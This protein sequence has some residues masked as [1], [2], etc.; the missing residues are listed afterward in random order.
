MLQTTA[1]QVVVKLLVSPGP[2]ETP[3]YPQFESL[4]GKAQSDWTK[5]QTGRAASA[6]EIAEVVD[7]LL[8]ADCGWLNGVDIPVDGGFTAGME[9]GW[10]DLA[11]APV[12][13]QRSS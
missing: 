5:A 8:T 12:M 13:Q 4:M 10:V 6:G 1:L 2:I 7:L 11:Q 9:S 3:L